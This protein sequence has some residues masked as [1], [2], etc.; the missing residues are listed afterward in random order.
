[1]KMSLKVAIATCFLVTATLLFTLP[2]TTSGA[3]DNATINVSIQSYTEIQVSPDFLQWQDVMP[4]TNGGQQYLEIKNIGSANVTNIYAYVN[5]TGNE[6]TRPYGTDDPWKYAATGLIVIRN[7]SG[8]RFF[9]AGRIEWNYTEDIPNKLMT[10]IDEP[11]AWGF[12]RNTSYEYFW[13]LGNGSKGACNESDTDLGFEDDV[14]NGTQASRTTDVT[15]VT[16]V[17]ADLNY[18][19]FYL[20]R[21]SQP[22][23]D[24]TCIAVN[25]ACDYIYLYKYDK[26]TSPRDYGIC[27][28]AAHLQV[29]DL[30]PKETHTVTLDAYAPYGIP[31]GDLATGN[32]YVIA[33]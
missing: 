1:M 29:E 15:G 5:T 13:G 27:N 12:V 10:G 24:D 8:T 33:S 6:S 20:D 17:Y 18:G 19:I 9:Y 25:A 32:I 21:A 30:A 14:D 26:R 2:R 4:G 31:D 16:H 23:L 7:E 28:V 3:A 22:L 11:V